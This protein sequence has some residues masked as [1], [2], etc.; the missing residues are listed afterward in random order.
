M[1]LVD[2]AQGA[3]AMEAGGLEAVVMVVAGLEVVV[4]AAE[5]WVR[6]GRSEMLEVRVEGRSSA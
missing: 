2:A 5:A 6:A 4:M 3:A 1:A